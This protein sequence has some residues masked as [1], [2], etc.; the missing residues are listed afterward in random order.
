VLV[1]ARALILDAAGSEIV[2]RLDRI[3][4]RDLFDIDADALKPTLEHDVEG[5]GQAGPV[6]LARLAVCQLNDVPERLD[7]QVYRHRDC[8]DGIGHARDRGEIVR[9]VRQIAVLVGV[10]DEGGARREQQD[11]I[12]LGGDEGIDRQDAVAPGP[13]LDHDRLVPFLGQ[14]VR[15]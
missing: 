11:V 5:A 3:A 14:P 15:Q 2:N 12:I 13:V 10:A 4:V 9:F 6:E 8:D 7:R 1:T